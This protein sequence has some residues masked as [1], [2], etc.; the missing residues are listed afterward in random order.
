MCIVL[1]NAKIHGVLRHHVYSTIFTECVGNPHD[2]IPEV[3]S[4]N[5]QKSVQSRYLQVGFQS[6]QKQSLSLLRLARV[7]LLGPSQNRR[8]TRA[9]CE[10]HPVRTL[11]S[12]TVRNKPPN[13]HQVARHEG[14]RNILG[15]ELDPLRV[16]PVQPRDILFPRDSQDVIIGHPRPP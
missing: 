15:G 7:I 11:A 6:H 3:A 13:R 16:Q 12:K 5:H 1:K 4:F 10:Q 2:A 9:A 8:I 14:P